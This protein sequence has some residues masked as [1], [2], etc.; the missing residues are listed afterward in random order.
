MVIGTSAR[1]CDYVDYYT[2]ASTDFDGLPVIVMEGEENM[3]KWGEL[4]FHA[5]LL[6]GTPFDACEEM[7][8]LFADDVYRFLSMRGIV[9][10][11][12]VAFSRRVRCL[13]AID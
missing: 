4:S 9:F 1:R 7:D 3:L 2:V 8:E 11:G 6:E 12:A 5:V 13:V 10:C